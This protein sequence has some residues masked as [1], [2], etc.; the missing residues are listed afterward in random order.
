[1]AFK[2]ISSSSNG[3]YT[4]ERYTFED[5]GDVLEGT[6][7]EKVTLTKDGRSFQKY[8]FKTDSGYVSTLGSHQI[9][10]ALASINTGT[11]VRIT[12]QGDKKLGGGKRVKQFL[13]EADT[14][15]APVTAADVIKAARVG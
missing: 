9:D 3:G 14:D 10:S 2:P 15:S 11:L 13:I 6:L 5:K 7:V 1:M 8:T 12:Y 4:A